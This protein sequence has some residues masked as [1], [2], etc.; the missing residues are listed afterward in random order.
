MSR[1]HAIA[2]RYYR[3]I[4]LTDQGYEAMDVELDWERTALVAMHCWDIGRDGGPAIDP[5]FLVGMGTYE[6]F[7]EADRI[8]TE[9]IRPAMDAARQAG[10]LV[11]HV[12]CEE[13]WRRSHPDEAGEADPPAAPPASAMPPVVPGWRQRIM[14]RSHGQDYAKVSPYARM[15]R[16]KIAA[17]LADEP[18]VCDTAAFDSVLRARG[19]ENLVY[20]GFAAD[21]CVLRA[22]GGVEPMAGF[23][24]RLFLMRDATVGIEFPDTFEERLA[25]RWAIRYFETHWGDTITTADFIGA[26]KSLAPATP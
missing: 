24:Y 20:S 17:P 25:T 23:G 15:D 1:N 21:M 26:C 5:D 10:V 19:I 7:R 22:P 6:S 12:E 4:P 16:A 18:Y 13:I 11:C 2:A 9:C 14:A 3:A 8:M